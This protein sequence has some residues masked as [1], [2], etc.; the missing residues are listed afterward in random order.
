[1]PVS[2]QD[3]AISAP[4]RLSA[5]RQSLRPRCGFSSVLK[6]GPSAKCQLETGKTTL[7][8]QAEDKDEAEEADVEAIYE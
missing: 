3:T 4:T 1:M 8:G 7:E 6:R 2:R 5:A